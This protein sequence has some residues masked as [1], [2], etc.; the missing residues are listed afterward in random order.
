MSNSSTSPVTSMNDF[1]EGREGGGGGGG[2][3]G[4]QKVYI[5]RRRNERYICR[6]KEK[7]E[8]RNE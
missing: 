1:A 8:K 4:G 7:E 6:M 5:R 2:M 3:K